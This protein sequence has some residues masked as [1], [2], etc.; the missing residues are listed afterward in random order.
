MRRVSVYKTSRTTT[1]PTTT[2]ATITLFFYIIGLPP[3]YF[4]LSFFV[5]LLPMVT[6]VPG[7]YCLPRCCVFW[8][9]GVVAVEVFPGDA[10]G[11]G[12]V[13]DENG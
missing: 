1:A 4:I 11:K 8:Q 6:L 5:F 12:D 13:S 10:S 2:S 9:H 3:I 7:Y